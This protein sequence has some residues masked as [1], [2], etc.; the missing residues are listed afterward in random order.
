MK[1][2]QKNTL[3]VVLLLLAVM[4]GVAVSGYLLIQRHVGQ[5]IDQ[6]IQRAHGVFVEAQKTAF[7]RMVSTARGIG[8]EPALMAAAITGDAATVR[9]MLEDLFPRP[10]IDLL[11]IYLD[12]G[13]GNVV[14]EGRKPHFTSPQVLASR[15]L[16]ELVQRVLGGADA[17]FGNALI[18]D[19]FL[20]LAATPIQAPDGTPIGVLLLGEEVGQPAVARLKELV[21]ADV[22]LF[23]GQAVLGSTLPT[24]ETPFAELSYG[25]NDR[26]PL[27]F[28]AGGE[29]Y[30]GHVFRVLAGDGETTAAHLLLAHPAAHY[31]APYEALGKRA[32][33]FSAV[34]LVV[35]GVF[36]VAV[37]GATLTRPVLALVKATRQIAS[38]DLNHK[39]NIHRRD[40]LGQLAQAFNLMLD[41]LGASQAELER[42][43]QRFHDFAESSSD[44]LWETD[45][46]CRFVYVSSS[47]TTTMGMRP[48]EFIGRRLDEIFVRDDM[49]DVMARLCPDRE[50]YYPFR[51]LELTLTLIDGSRRHLRLN[52]MPVL[53]GGHFRGYRGTASDISKAKQ[54]E[55]RLT[56]LANQDQMTGL[57]NR[58]RF[59]IDL[60]H[61]IRR[62]QSR[63]TRG[64]L[65]LI[66]LDHLKL[67][68]DAAGH[69]VGDEIIVQV[70]GVLN[71]LSRKEDLVA[72]VSGDEFAM[73]FPEM[74]REQALLKARQVLD[75]VN[76]CRPIHGGQTINVTASVGLVFF[77]D[78]GGQAV[79]LM[80]MADTAMYAAKDGGRNR[81]Q[82]YSEA[83]TARERMGSQLAW[84]NK[85]LEAIDHELFELVF[86]PIAGV[87]DGQVHHFETLVRIRDTDGNSLMPGNFIPA[88]EQFG[89][90]GQV[91]RII[92][93]KA[94]AYLA[95]LPAD[96]ASVGISINLSGLSVG[97]EAML[98]FIRETLGDSGVDPSRI[99]FEVTET[100]ACENMSRAVEFIAR[101]RQLGCRISLDD[102]GVGFSSFSYLK[103]LKVDI[104][105]IDGSFIRDITRNRE[106]R[107][108][109]KAL[110]DVARGLGIRTIAEYVESA[111][112]FAL[113]RRIGV[114]YVQGY[115]VGRPQPHIERDKLRIPNLSGPQVAAG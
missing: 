23:H 104:L 86:Q 28:L 79:E 59:L 17:A 70:A 77:P 82:V 115:F 35:A 105:K 50:R 89:L 24:P 36:G 84:K 39:V 90:I 112:A 63:G 18:F 13:G 88:A 43:R 97:D 15:P 83:D 61:E 7:D 33:L 111:E 80:A 98:D 31:W 11:A 2:G 96:M 53:E 4:I 108:F 94:V 47:I 32:L 51:D 85:V 29:R 3:F 75:A 34:I 58:R 1:L 22:A 57:A 91:D 16:D 20:R 100:A 71:R 5:M 114:D 93:R 37:S 64:A 92:M 9:S 65:L 14:A 52:G 81:I 12:A 44:W 55:E 26:R 41:N 87:V 69:A 46:E 6:D 107:L 76:E 99:T 110:V 42:N 103:N 109:V 48:D 54:D 45:A 49:S 25:G 95:G 67:I 78:Q 21:S 27:A 66:D 38:G 62:S 106:D 72:R 102:F 74:D 113:L 101:V 8:R 73:A 56:V 60:A 68:N 40:E 10:G 19:T 30:I